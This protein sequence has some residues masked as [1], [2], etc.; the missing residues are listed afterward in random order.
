MSLQ[1]ATVAETIAA[2]EVDGLEI[3]DIDDIPAEAGLRGALL[4]PLPAYVTDFTMTRVSFG[5]GAAKIDVTYT[6]NY[7]LLYAAI[8]TDRALNL[9]VWGGMVEMVAA[10]WDAFIAI[11]V[12]DDEHTEVVDV[13]PLAPAN[14]GIVNDPSDR[15]FYGCDLAFQVT[16][17]A[18]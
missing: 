6:L 15:A 17:F 11:G 3:R 2:L 18:R 8:G 10:I 12:F 7:R 1:L 14:M 13:T 9:S 5:G 4:I 16:E